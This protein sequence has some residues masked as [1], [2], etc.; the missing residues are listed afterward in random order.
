MSCVCWLR[1]TKLYLS[2]WEPPIMCLA[3]KILKSLG[4]NID[5]KGIPPKIIFIF[6]LRFELWHLCKSMLPSAR[7]LS[8]YLYVIL[9]LLLS[10]QHLIE[11]PIGE[12]YCHP[13][14]LSIVNVE[15][16]MTRYLLPWITMSS[17]CLNFRGA[18]HL[19]FAVSE[20]AS[21]IPCYHII[22]WLFWK[23]VGI[24]EIL[25]VLA[26]WLCHWYE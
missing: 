23:I 2:A 15:C 8:I 9:V 1:G 7:G 19:C 20:R 26:S 10:H 21:E 4:H 22:R 12:H 25:L 24:R 5:R 16:D 6:V 13:Y 11:A 3:C 17:C 14:A 18:L